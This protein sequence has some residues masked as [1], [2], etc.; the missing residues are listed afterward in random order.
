MR[1]DH[2]AQAFGVD[3]RA[4]AVGVRQ[5]CEELLSARTSAEVLGAAQGRGECL[6]DGGE[7]VVAGLVAVAVVDVLKVVKVKR[8]H[9]Q[10]LTGSLRLSDEALDAVLQRAGV[11]QAGEGVGRGHRLGYR[12]GA[13]VRQHGG[14]LGDRQADLLA[15][16]LVERGGREIST[17]PITS[18][19]TREGKHVVRC[20]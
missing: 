6:A 15:L 7:H 4:G 14:G 3:Q 19:P 18:P 16:G 13:Q 9:G 8:E 11:G 12:Q 5:Q 2:A 1:G 17:D 10:R 20:A